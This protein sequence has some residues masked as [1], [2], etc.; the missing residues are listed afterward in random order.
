MTDAGVCA[1]L[2]FAA[3]C[4]DAV[5]LATTAPA[6]STWGAPGA[7]TVTT[8]TF[9]NPHPR[10]NGPIVVYRPA[11]QSSVPVLF[12][13]HAFGATDPDLYLDLFQMLASQGYA[14]VYVPY[15]TVVVA[16]RPMEE[17][18]D[19]LFQGFQTAVTTLGST[20]DT[21]RVGFFGHSFGAGAT[22]ELARR[23]FVTQGWGRNG[24]FMF[25]MA[26]W[27]S[28]GRLY[29]TLPTDVRTVIQ[30]YADDEV[31]DHQTAVQDIWNRLPAGIERAWM[32][33]RSDVCGC[34]LNA[35]HTVPMTRVGITMNPENTVNGH[36]RWVVWRRLHALA[37]Y[38][39]TQNAQAR[40]VAMGPDA[41]LGVF[42]GCGRRAVRPLEVSR[43]TPLP[44]PCHPSRF[45]QSSRCMFADPGPCP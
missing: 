43:T 35:S 8:Q 23:G 3:A 38:A 17:R 2:P 16:L 1:S 40:D 45:P 4:D 30:V 44:A 33:V 18:Y 26:P 31:N 25:I 13:S 14:V 29:N 22:P 11:G 9:A 39:F 19:V 7:F 10:A 36:D 6:A 37:V 41:D 12:F 21:T 5:A 34:G 20:I 42:L 27:Y 32:T 24:R 28:W 15:P